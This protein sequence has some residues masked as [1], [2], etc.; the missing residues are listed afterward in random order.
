MSVSTIIKHTAAIAHA[1]AIHHMERSTSLLQSSE[2][3]NGLRVSTMEMLR[4]RARLRVE[5]GV[6]H[7]WAHR[8]RGEHAR[9][10]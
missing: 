7:R 3:E 10:R 1:H 9:S 2:G 8:L 5:M 4:E 6:S